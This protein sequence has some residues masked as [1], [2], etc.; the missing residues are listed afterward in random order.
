[1]IITSLA[2]IFR[3]NYKKIILCACILLIAHAALQVWYVF[4]EFIRFNRGIETPQGLILAGSA[5]FIIAFFILS[6]VKAG[7]KFLIIL[8]SIF[9]VYPVLVGVLG[10][11]LR[12]QQFFRPSM[13]QWPVSAALLITGGVFLLLMLLVLIEKLPD[14]IALYLPALFGLPALIAGFYLTASSLFH[15][16][17]F[18]IFFL[19]FLLA[20]LLLLATAVA[21][22]ITTYRLVVKLGNS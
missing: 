1:M 11:Y 8:P 7:Y 4:R 22:F 5:L 13:L 18:D 19:L 15:R 16:W 10:L 12:S 6:R 17:H 20:G 9:A 14:T 21:L 3:V 2:V